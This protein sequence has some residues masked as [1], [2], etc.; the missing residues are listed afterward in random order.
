MTIL[1]GSQRLSHMIRNMR[2]VRGFTD[3]DKTLRAV[4]RIPGLPGDEK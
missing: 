3:F 1:Q 4:T 2:Y